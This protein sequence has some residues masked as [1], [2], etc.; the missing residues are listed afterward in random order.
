MHVVDGGTAAHKR[1]SA[2]VRANCCAVERR[3]CWRG[4][5]RTRCA[6]SPAL[7]RE[8]G[9]PQAIH[10]T[11]DVMQLHV[12]YVCVGDNNS[13]ST[14]TTTN[15]NNNQQKTASGR[16]AFTYIQNNLPSFPP[17]AKTQKAFRQATQT[18]CNRIILLMRSITSCGGGVIARMGDA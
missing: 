8:D 18:F 6:R 4:N 5:T 1:T 9:R 3:L 10:P 14:T 12:M 17:A 7:R 15:N 11:D 13:N 2:S 16:R